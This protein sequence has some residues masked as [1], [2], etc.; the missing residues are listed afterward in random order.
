MLPQSKFHMGA[1]SANR[2]EEHQSGPADVASAG[3]PRPVLS[4]PL[5]P[6][7]PRVVVLVQKKAKSDP[8]TQKVPTLL[9]Q[10]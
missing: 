6:S 8:N 3:L 2:S 9:K 10:N 1:L 5:P 7:Q 4:E